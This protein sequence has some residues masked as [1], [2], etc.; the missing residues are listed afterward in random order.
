MKRK[1][2]VYSSKK[3]DDFLSIVNNQKEIESDFPYDREDIVF[4]VLSFLLYYCIAIPILWT[5]SKINN[6]TKIINKKK[7][8]KQ[9][10]N[11]GFII[12]SNHT[13]MSD[14]FIPAVFTCNPKRT[15][16][17]SLGETLMVNKV[18]RY[19]LQLLGATPLPGDLHSGKNFLLFLKKK[20]NHKCAV[21]IFPEATIWPY[22]TGQR[23]IREGSFKYPRLFNK[24][25]VFACTTFRKP[26][27]IFKRFLKPKVV[28]YLSEPVYPHRKDSEKEDEKRIE[29]LYVQFIEKMTS[30]PNNYAANNYVLDD[31]EI[32][33]FKE[34]ID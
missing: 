20:L 18:S 3:S 13:M 19:F 17:I 25:A 12:Y 6:R 23:P 28:I 14:G 21:A 27:G 11:T 7:V 32:Q 2:F 34:K 24:P 8:R 26:K 5:I 16:I 31:S 22:Y 30:L 29:S 10:K 15:Y 4:K 33:K 1:T 9:L